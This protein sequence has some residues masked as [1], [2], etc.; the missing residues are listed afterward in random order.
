MIAGRERCLRLDHVTIDTRNAPVMISFLESILGVKEG[1]LTTLF[2]HQ[3]D[4]LYLDD[5]PLSI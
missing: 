3:A 4:W 1:Y 5:K 2:L